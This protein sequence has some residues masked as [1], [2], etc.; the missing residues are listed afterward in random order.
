MK[1]VVCFHFTGDWVQVLRQSAQKINR[2]LILKQF[3]SGNIYFL[4][5]RQFLDGDRLGQ[6][7]DQ[8]GFKKIIFDMAASSRFT[9]NTYKIVRSFVTHCSKFFQVSQYITIIS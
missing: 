4:L 2:Q 7:S 6:I 1:C 8:L 3:I 5:V 9:K